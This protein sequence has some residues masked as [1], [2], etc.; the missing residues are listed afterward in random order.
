[1]LVEYAEFH[2]SSGWLRDGVEAEPV[3]PE[4]L[5]LARFGERELQEGFDRVR[6]L[7]IG[8]RV[9]GGENEIVVAEA[10]D[11][12]VDGLFVGFHREEAVIAE[13]VRRLAREL[14][15]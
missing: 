11:V 3:V 7:R 9:V 12:V 14:R 15:Y 6:V 4:D 1:M 2:G 10:G 8:V 5:A 13:V